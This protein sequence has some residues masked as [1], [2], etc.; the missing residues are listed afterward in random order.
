MNTAV[1]EQPRT[2]AGGTDNKD[3]SASAGL[4]VHRSGDKPLPLSGNRFVVPTLPFRHKKNHANKTSSATILRKTGNHNAAFS[5]EGRG[6]SGDEDAV[7][8][9]WICA[10]CSSKNHTRKRDFCTICKQPKEEKV[11]IARRGR[12]QQRDNSNMPALQA[13]QGREGGAP[14]SSSSSPRRSITA[15]GSSRSW[16]PPPV[17]QR[18][19][20]TS[21]P[22]QQQQHMNT[23]PA[24]PPRQQQPPTVV[25]MN[26]FDAL[27]QAAPPHHHHHQHPPVVSPSPSY[28][29][30]N[31]SAAPFVTPDQTSRT[32]VVAVETV[33]S[34]DSDEE[35]YSPPPKAATS[36]YQPTPTTTTTTLPSPTHSAQSTPQQQQQQGRASS[37]AF[38]CTT[39]V[40]T[41]VHSNRRQDPFAPYSQPKTN[42]V[43]RPIESQGSGK[44]QVLTKPKFGQDW[45]GGTLV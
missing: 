45:E 14:Q 32:G 20:A 25:P 9:A 36:P 16:S 37:P 44:F 12:R 30:S 17:A 43:L 33:D 41:P 4:F 34:S 38:S 27:T 22:P 26:P 39:S 18:H 21:L 40:D 3:S 42:A 15:P 10:H 11:P 13:R 19:A 31:I 28:N 35:F 29:N 23:S 7:A 6:L 2:K 8:D 1:K 5:D 24:A